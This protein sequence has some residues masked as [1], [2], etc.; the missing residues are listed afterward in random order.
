MTFCI[1]FLV[2]QSDPI[3]PRSGNSSEERPPQQEEEEAEGRR[4]LQLGH[5]QED[6]GRASGHVGPAKTP[7]ATSPRFGAGSTSLRVDQEARAAKEGA[8]RS[9]PPSHRV[10]VFPFHLFSPS[11]HG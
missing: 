2:C 3:R 6:Q 9:V 11:C 8:D 7:P 5:R 10:Q 4:R 1:V